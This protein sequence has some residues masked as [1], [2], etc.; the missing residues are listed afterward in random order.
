M[1]TYTTL[2]GHEITYTEPDADSPLGQQLARIRAAV[3]DPNATLNDVTT[4][5]YGPDNPLMRQGVIPGWGYV[6]ATIAADPLYKVM[7]DLLEQKRFQA[8]GHDLKA[9]HDAYTM[10]V[11]EAAAQLGIS[12][13]AVRKAIKEERLGAVKKGSHYR[14]RP[15]D[16][17]AYTVRRRGPAPKPKAHTPVAQPLIGEPLSFYVGNVEQLGAR[18]LHD[19]QRVAEQGDRGQVV[20]WT[21]LAWRFYNKQRQQ[22]LFI[23]IVPA[24]PSEPTDT[25]SNGPFY[26]SGRFRVVRRE[27]NPRQ[28]QAAWKAFPRPD[29]VAAK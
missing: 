15:S 11:T 29:K 17:E 28:A 25:I 19:G 12:D 8:G 6:D 7:R 9:T 16:V 21:R 20:G 22:Q 23:E 3:A 13:V 10:T 27:S 18:M 2:D 4:L 26:L 24:L 14:L 5:V 1:L